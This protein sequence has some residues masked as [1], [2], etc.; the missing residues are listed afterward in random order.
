MTTTERLEEHYSLLADQKLLRIAVYE[1]RGLTPEALIVLN[2]ELRERG[3]LEQVKDLID[4]Q[5]KVLDESE[6]DSLVEELRSCPCPKC[7]KS[8][9]DLNAWTITR[10][11]G[12]LVVTLYRK[13][14][15]I[16]CPVCIKKEAKEAT[17]ISISGLFGFPFGIILMVRAIWKNRKVI[18]HDMIRPSEELRNFVRQQPG[19]VLDMIKSNSVVSPL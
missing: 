9:Q 1:A 17:A 14:L 4:V 12:F 19:A 2:N 8:D 6:L 18:K 16:A 5:T 3:L 13:G 7:G 11:M 15:M 10:V